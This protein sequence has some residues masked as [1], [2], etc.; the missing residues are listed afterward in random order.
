VA[1]R[2]QIPQLIGEEFKGQARRPAA[3]PAKQGE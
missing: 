1:G 3:P 2:A